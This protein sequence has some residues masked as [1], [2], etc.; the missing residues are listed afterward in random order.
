MQITRMEHSRNLP[1]SRLRLAPVEKLQD[2]AG[3]SRIDLVCCGDVPVLRPRKAFLEISCRRCGM[4]F[5]A[6]RNN[7]SR[8]VQ[9]EHLLGFRARRGIAIKQIAWNIFNDSCVLA[10]VEADI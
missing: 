8:N 10:G 2:P 7:E 5:I 4:R 9:S 3:H 6:A 1:N